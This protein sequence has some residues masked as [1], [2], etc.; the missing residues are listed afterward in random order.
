[1][2]KLVKLYIRHT[3]IG[4]AISAL[5]VALLLWLNVGNLFALISGSSTGY[6]AGFMLFMFNGIV[7]SGVQFG[8]AIM[9]MADA[10]DDTP[11]GRRERIK[12]PVAAP[13]PVPATHNQ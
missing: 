3:L 9:R 12:A 4:F 7:F 2:P 8:I 1:M 5:F 6:L 13:I 11:K 10:P